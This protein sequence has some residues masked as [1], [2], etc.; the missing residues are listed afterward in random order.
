MNQAATFC[1]MQLH[2]PG[3]LS[4]QHKPTIPNGRESLAARHR[5]EMTKL[6]QAEGGSSYGRV[7]VERLFEDAARNRADLALLFQAAGQTSPVP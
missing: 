5:V 3:A 4:W 2:L 6:V 7:L 1:S